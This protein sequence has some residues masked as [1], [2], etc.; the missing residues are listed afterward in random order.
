MKNYLK[1]MLVV[2]VASAGMTFQSCKSTSAGYQSSPVVSR[3]VELDP[4][5]A[6]IKVDESK[7]LE[8]HSAATYLFGFRIKGDK[9]YADGI[10]YSTYAGS[11]M[12]SFRGIREHRI[13][14]AAAYKALDGQDVDFM[15]HPTYTVKRKWFLIGTKYE[16]SVSGYGAKYENFRTEPDT[17]RCCPDRVI[18][19]GG[20]F[21]R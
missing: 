6:D 1:L 16:I 3:N 11:A 2:L 19:G 7:K 12:I 5:K 9:E 18:G 20:L 14:S 13:K 10:S 21:G 4:I 17:L 8:G 15:V